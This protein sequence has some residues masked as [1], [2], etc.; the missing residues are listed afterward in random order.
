VAPTRPQPCDALVAL[1]R[2]LHANGALVTADVLAALGEAARETPGLADALASMT[3]EA[4]TAE[5][6]ANVDASGRPV[7]PDAGAPEALTVLQAAAPD[8]ADAFRLADGQ[9]HV[10]RW[11]ANLIGARHAVVDVFLDPAEAPACTLVQVRSLGKADAPGRFDVAVGGHVR[12]ADAPGH[13]LREEAGEELGLDPDRDFASLV[14]LDG[15]EY[16]DPGFDG[17]F[18]N[19]EY[20]HLYRAT[21]TP[22]ALGRLRY[23]D[24]E[25]AAVALFDR[26]ELARLLREQPEHC[27]SGLRYSGPRYLARREPA[28]GSAGST[29]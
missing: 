7:A 18:R 27:A 3:P 6:L 4:R 26:G 5:F 15:Y 25:V 23:A 1:R 24:G 22:G 16:G 17:V 20:R 19:I 28:P 29:D 14:F 11:L 12:G 2:V 10:A 13:A 9:V 21:L 8:L